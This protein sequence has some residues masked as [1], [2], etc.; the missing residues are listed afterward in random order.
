MRFSSLFIIGLL[1]CSAEE[2]PSN[3]HNDA[4]GDGYALIDDCNDAD[5]TVHPGADDEVGDGTDNNCVGIDGVDADA[6]GFASLDSGGDDC[7]DSNDTAHPSGTEIPY[8]GVDQDCL[9]GDLVD[10]DG[11]GFSSTEAG[12]DDCDDNDER[13]RPEAPDDVGDGIDNNCD[14]IDGVDFD[15]DG[16]ASDAGGGDDCDDTDPA[17]NPAGL[18]AWYDGI[19]GDCDY[20]CDYDQDNDGFVLL[21]YVSPDNGLCD[22]EPAVGV[23]VALQDCDDSDPTVG[24]NDVLSLSPYDT[25]P[26]AFYH[27][28]LEVLLLAEDLTAVISLDDGAGLPVPGVSTVIANTVSFDP[29]VP[30]APLTDYEATLTYG[31]GVVTWT[32]T[33][34]DGAPAAD[35]QLLPGST[36]VMDL[37]GGNWIQPLG[38]AALL[39]LDQNVLLEVLTA[40]PDLSVRLALDDQGNGIQ[41]TCIAT[42]EPM[43]RAFDANP[44]F[45]LET[46][47]LPVGIQGLN[48]TLGAV[49]FSGR[50]TQDGSQ[51]DEITM[52]SFIDTRP[53]VPLIGGGPPDAVCTLMVA[54]GVACETCPSDGL[55]LCLELLIEDLVADLV[56]AQSLVPRTQLE[57]DN[58]PSCP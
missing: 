7:D 44:F 28:S 19:D 22:T 47:D 39:Q 26:D 36:Y 41:D 32:F 27:S 57:V 15:Q 58:D 25:Q 45:D 46:F 23:V 8:D 16:Y 53:I 56:P 20:V 42:V 24:P 49:D 18:D 14:G 40:D 55:P 17:V 50:F 2:K 48:L 11:D 10:V 35:D 13:T 12:G 52:R 30:L 54:F 4:D 43:P 38:I 37:S 29:D 5:K 1:G 33:T 31:C 9:D 6:D 34:R 3:D 21:G 51:I